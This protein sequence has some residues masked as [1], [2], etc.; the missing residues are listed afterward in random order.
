[1]SCEQSLQRQQAQKAALAK[2]AAYAPIK[3]VGVVEF[4][5]GPTFAVK[6]TRETPQQNGIG[7]QVKRNP[8]ALRWQNMD[9]EVVRADHN[10]SDYNYSNCDWR[11]W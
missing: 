9:S 2:R 11:N 8:Q 5:P 3:R 1:M 10:N 4:V 6:A 7:N